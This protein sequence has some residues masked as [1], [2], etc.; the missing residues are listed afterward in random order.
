MKN[1][2]LAGLTLPAVLAC[3]L[4]ASLARAAEP[5]GEW[6]GF[7]GPSR[8][9][10]S[11]EKGLL[12]AWPEGGP[13][14]L[15]RAPGG[16]GM[17][18]LAISGGKLVTLVQREG[19]QLVAAH[20]AATGAPLW[21]T[22]VAPAFRNQMGDG[23]RATPAIAGERVFV[24]TGEGI[25]AALHLADGK[26]LWSTPLLTELKG[27]LADYGMACSPLVVGDDVIV[28]VGAP[29]ATVAACDAQTGAVKWTAGKNDPAGY[30]SPALLNVGGEAQI[31]AF[32][33]GSALGIAPKTGALLWRFPYETDFACNIA[34]PLATSGGVFISS[35]E[36]HG[37][38]LLKPGKGEAVAV[39]ESLGPKSVLRCEWQTA[40]QLGDAL[41]GFDNV[42]GAGPVSHLTCIQAST[43]ERA[44]Q[45]PRFGK[46]NMISADGK[47]FIITIEGELVIVSADPA[48]FT[49]WGRADVLGMTRTAPALSA[50]RL[51]LRDDKEIVCLDVRK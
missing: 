28:C 40:I 35:G 30:S 18:G 34:T 36:N 51:Y 42:G 8:N 32:S 23:P 25:L 27:S 20:D 2:W 45:Q 14:V 1:R 24:F 4:S 49:E 22:A 29:G 47:L 48:K 43:G 38:V 10:V 5:V 31:V 26:P 11:A 6:P 12:A 21:T 15:W 13:K 44:W 7:L 17:S 50:G 3:S 19:K 16:V 46:G 37:S 39:W 9:G 33:G 41:Y